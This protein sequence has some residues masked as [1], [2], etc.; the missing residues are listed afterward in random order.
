ML[1]GEDGQPIDARFEVDGRSLIFLSRGGAKSKGAINS[2]YARGLRLLVNRSRDANAVII[3]AWVDSRAVQLLPIEERRIITPNS[4]NRD[5]EV[6][7]S[8]M[9][10]RMQRVGQSDGVRGGNSTKRI[11]LLFSR[12]FSESEVRD[13]LGGIPVEGGS[14]GFDRL[15]VVELEKVTAENVWNAVQQLLDG[16]VSHPFRESGDF[17]LI[18]DGGVRLAPEAVFGIAASLALGFEVLPWH[19][20]TG[21]KS[22]CFRIL[23][24]SGYMVIP[25]AL[26][27]SET[28]AEQLLPDDYAMTEGR[29]RL[30]SHLKRERAW[31][32]AQAK[33]SQFKALHGRLFCERC[34][35]DPVAQY[36][37]EYG[38]AC[39]EV[40]HDEV[41]VKDMQAGHVTR[42]ESL[43]CLCA[44]CHRVEHCRLR[45][46]A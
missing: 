31:G 39:I 17:D 13:L 42:L 10:R 7:L 1:I 20:T 35:M 23:R 18:A 41:Q 9:T 32:L 6:I 34:K 24:R 36:G 25:K 40:H 8:E 21:D 45:A 3:D 38:E 29:P 28:N 26:S 22:P 14:R 11:R 19:F 15:P 43:K 27:H 4:G 46:E 2:D 44:N 5:P 12:D 16:E 37:P 33:K 30:V